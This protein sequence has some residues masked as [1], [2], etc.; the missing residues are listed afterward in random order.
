M[1]KLNLLLLTALLMFLL[2]ISACSEDDNDDNDGDNG[3]PAEPSFSFTLPDSSE[4]AINFVSQTVD[5]NG[6]DVAGYSLDQFIPEDPY[7]L[8]ASRAVGDE[9][10]DDDTRNLFVFELVGT[11]GFT[12]RQRGEDDLSWNTF[13][14]GYLLP[15]ES[16]KAFFADEEI[17]NTY[18]V[19]YMDKFN[20]YRVLRVAKMDVETTFM[21][22]SYK[23]SNVSFTDTKDNAVTYEGFKLE[24]MINPDVTT[25]PENYSYYVGAVDGWINNDTNNTFTWE[26]MQNAYFFPEENRVCFVENGTE[27]FKP[28]KSPYSIELTETNPPS[29]AAPTNLTVDTDTDIVLSWTDNSDNETGFKI[30][31]KYESDD[32]YVLIDSVDADV[33]TY[34]DANADL[35]QAIKYRVAAYNADD[36]SYYSNEVT[37][38]AVSAPPALADTTHLA[39]RFSLDFSDMSVYTSETINVDGE[40][41]TAYKL[42]QFIDQEEVTTLYGEDG[43]DCRA[44]YCYHIV[45]GDGYSPRTRG[46]RD[47]TWAEFSSGYWLEGEQKAY[48]PSDDISRQYNVGDLTHIDLYNTINISDADGNLITPFEYFGTET[49]SITYIHHEEEYTE[50]AVPLT[51]IIT[52]YVTTEPA[53][54]TYDFAASDGWET[55]PV[56]WE[57]MQ[58]GYWL[59]NANKA[60]FIDASGNQVLTGIKNVVGIQL[61]Q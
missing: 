4:L 53:S 48:F 58:K 14:T 12:P 11:D 44:F 23:T 43:V 31:R 37:I 7:D 38:D 16:Y 3:V 19:K 13:K 57:N 33:T 2:A 46:N 59:V 36:M 41:V 52:S 5:Y 51:S 35:A 9:I 39:V 20:L 50:D 26:Q 6:T 28:V 22:G 34:T 21:T 40:D 24:D 49:Q 27:V 45:A 17:V 8:E 61:I 32:A 55:D 60:V 47:L 56:T 54:Y 30:E 29:V 18:N 1:K 10:L 15:T 42:D 25:S